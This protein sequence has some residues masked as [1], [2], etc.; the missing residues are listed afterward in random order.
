MVVCKGITMNGRVHRNPATVSNRVRD[1]IAYGL[2]LAP[3]HRPDM[4]SHG[5]IFLTTKIRRV[6]AYA[7]FSQIM[8]ILRRHQHLFH[9]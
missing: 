2:S 3:S 9:M 7:H 8:H 5:K 6:L 1:I 4:P